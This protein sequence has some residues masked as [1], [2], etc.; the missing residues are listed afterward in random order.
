MAINLPFDLQEGTIA[1]ARKVMANL[2]AL[3]GA[4]NSVVISEDR[5]DWQPGEPL[6]QGDVSTLL[7][8][9]F[10][11]VVMANEEGNSTKIRFLD[12]ENLEEKFAAGTLNASILDSQG[13][14]YF[15]VDS[16]GHLI[17]TAAEGV[18]EENFEVDAL[19]GHLIYTLKDPEDSSEVTT[20]DLGQVKG[21]KGDKGD[22]GEDGTVFYTGYFICYAAAWDADTKEYVLRDENYVQ[23]EET[24]PGGHI[25]GATLDG[26]ITALTGHALIGPNYNVATD[27]EVEAWS[28]AMVRVVSQG[29]GE[30][31]FKALG[32]IPETDVNLQITMFV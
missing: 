15:E 24:M 22:P 7:S 18:D 3:L 1:Y 10:Q 5:I 14:F 23:D 27:E 2:R 21:G 13:L 28:N 30:I 6:P 9:L 4:Y 12:G 16:A 26:H 19:T 17:V 25:D 20:Y 32:D 31:V 29:S 11:A 8:L